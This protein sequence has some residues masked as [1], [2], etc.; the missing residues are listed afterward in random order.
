MYHP[1][2][3]NKIRVVFDCSAKCQ[4]TSLND[5]LLQGPNLTNGLIGVLVRFR[6]ERI[7]LMCD[8]EMIFH[9]FRVDEKDR[10]YLRFL[11]MEEGYRMKVHLFGATS[12]P[13]CTNYGLKQIAKD[14][15]EDSPE[16]ANFI[17]KNFYV[18]DGLTS[19]DSF[20]S[21]KKL[22]KE[23][24]D[25]CA[26]G[27]LRLHKFI[28]NSREVMEMIPCSERANDLKDID[29]S[30]DDLPI[31]RALGIQWC[32]IRQFPVPT[33]A[34][35]STTGPSR[36]PVHCSICLRPAGLSGTIR[37]Y[38][39]ANLGRDVQGWCRLG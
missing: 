29:L 25:M 27:N 19:V 39:E 8:V 30:F 38:R 16:V 23:A 2:K 7:A 4:G 31:E 26:K 33:C 20:K 32:G 3:P 11:W 15:E 35:G 10:N 13:G 6:Q 22:I 21:A 37:A 17:R 24:R 36:H 12:S 34:Q 1:K 14:Y 18:N 28:S 5:L 9:Q